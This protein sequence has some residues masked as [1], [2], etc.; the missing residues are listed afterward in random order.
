MATAPSGSLCGTLAARLCRAC[1]RRPVL[2]ISYEIVLDHC[3]QS[4]QHIPVLKPNVRRPDPLLKESQR[5][6][7]QDYRAAG[8]SVAATIPMMKAQHRAR[9]ISQ[10]LCEQIQKVGR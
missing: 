1:F 10:S 3:P 6:G 4:D 5:G 8:R 2:L 7:R 9:G